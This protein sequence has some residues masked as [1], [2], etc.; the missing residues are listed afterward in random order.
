[1]ENKTIRKEALGWFKS[2]FRIVGDEIHTSKF[3]TPEDRGVNPEF[4]FFR[5][6]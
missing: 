3:Y 4:G 1:M 5:Y 2:K 6:H